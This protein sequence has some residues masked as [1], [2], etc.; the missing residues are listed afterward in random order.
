MVWRCINMKK[1]ALNQI[2]AAEILKTY[3]DEYLKNQIT[4]EDFEQNIKSFFDTNKDKLLKNNV[5]ASKPKLKLG[6]KRLAILYKIL[7][8]V[9]NG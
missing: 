6:K 4:D 1:Y 2:H 8:G 3:I 9:L 5:L 7:G